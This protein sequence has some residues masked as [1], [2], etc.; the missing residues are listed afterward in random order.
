[1]AK[2]RRN[3]TT[4]ELSGAVTIGTSQGST[5]IPPT[6]PPDQPITPPTTGPTTVDITI[7]SISP[8]NECAQNNSCFSPDPVTI[9]VGDTVKWTNQN[10]DARYLLSGTPS[11]PTEEFDSELIPSGGAFSYTFRSA[12]TFDYFDIVYPWEQGRV[13]VR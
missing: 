6:T 4:S 5:V 10:A 11:V 13:I 12:G 2:C 9:N 7:P 3:S 1:M 8:S